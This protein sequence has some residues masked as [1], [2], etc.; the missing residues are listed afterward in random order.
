MGERK[1]PLGLFILGVF[2]NLIKY[3]LFILISLI[4]III[5]MFD[6]KS[7]FVIGSSIIGVC[8]LLSIIEQIKITKVCLMESENEDFNNIMDAYLG[9]KNN[10]NNK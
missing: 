9:N 5:G 4:L 10:R 8:L 3:F 1:Y 2:S 6:A 7:Y